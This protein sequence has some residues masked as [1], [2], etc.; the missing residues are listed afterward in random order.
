MLPFFLQSGYKSNR[1]ADF[2][3]FVMI[4]VAS[5][6]TVIAGYRDIRKAHEQK[7]ASRLLQAAI[8]SSLSE[9][10]PVQDITVL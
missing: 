1:F 7:I 3:L 6:I 9:Y 2:I 5:S 4:W 8:F 10:H